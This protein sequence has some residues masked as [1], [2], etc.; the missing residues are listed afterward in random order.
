MSSDLH[1]VFIFE[2]FLNKLF[3]STLFELF[4]T[5]HSVHIF[6]KRDSIG[7]KKKGATLFERRPIRVYTTDI[8]VSTTIGCVR[9]MVYGLKDYSRFATDNGII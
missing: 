7:I 1:S 4:S 6:H 2:Y 8:R 3:I 5:L 9:Y